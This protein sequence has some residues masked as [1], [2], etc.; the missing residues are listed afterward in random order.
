MVF[1]LTLA[2]ERLVLY[3]N[4]AFSIL[5]FS[6]KKN[7][8]PVFLKRFLFLKKFVSKSKQSPNA[9]NLPSNCHIETSLSVK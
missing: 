2:S 1:D 6:I 4:D 8:T 9:Q 7:G 3:E 5:V